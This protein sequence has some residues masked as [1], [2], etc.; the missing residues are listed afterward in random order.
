MA[1]ASPLG[2]FIERRTALVERATPG[3]A[4]AAELARLTNEAV[5]AQVSMAS[6]FIGTPFAVFALG[7]YG[8]GRLLPGSDID[9]LIVPTGSSRDV[10]PLVRCLLYP[11]WDA[12][13]TVGHQIRTPKDQLRAVREDLTVATSFLTARCVAGDGTLAK[14]VIG[15]VFARLARDRR[16]L[17]ERVTARERPGSPYQLEP[18]LKDGAGGQR[19]IDELVWRAALALGAPASTPVGLLESGLLTDPEALLLES[20]QDA[21]TGA[22]WVVH[23]T[24]ARVSNTLCAME[25]DLLLDAETTQRALELTH[26]TLI[27]VRDRAARRPPAPPD[28]MSLDEI[29]GLAQ[30]GTPGLAMLERATYAGRLEH[31]IPGLQAMMALRRPSLSHRYTVGAHSLRVLTV[32]L[33]ASATKPPAEDTLHALVIAALTHDLGKQTP[34]P[35]HAARSATLTAEVASRFGLSQDVG[36]AAEVLVREHLLL[37]EVAT[38]RDLTDEDVI[39]VSAARIGSLALV[40]PLFALTAADMRATGPDV[41]TPWRATLVA[42]LAN[43]LAD[44]LSPEIDGAGII[45]AAENTRE[46][47]RVTALS[48]GASRVVL[49][50]LEQAPLRYLAHR[51]AKE[52]LRDAL[53]VQSIAGPGAPGRFALGISPGPTEGTWV[54]DLIT[55]DRPGLFAII[56]GTL[57]LCGLDTLAAEAHAGEAGI[58]LDTFTVTSATR[59]PVGTETWSAV[60][61]VLCAALA[62]RYDIDTRLAKRRLHYPASSDTAMPVVRTLTAT[63]LTATVSIKT[64]DR[65]GLLHDLAWAC[66]SADLDIRRAVITTRGNVA[67]DVFELTDAEGAPPSR[68]TITETLIPLLE[69]AAPAH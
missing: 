66:R 44:A 26:H 7:G 36:A 54:M 29:V 24:S 61:R 69:Q 12:G 21:I 19:D 53:L 67:D 35:G 4:A 13:L 31:A 3:T 51:D 58:A 5:F 46:A 20:A 56:S 22:R 52:V 37:S 33:D 64:P 2:W 49:G 18:D 28:P 14:H 47:A 68:E 9:L 23:R 40:E 15:S 48:R 38:T 30:T 62:G 10:E 50:F 65:V 42:E 6:S 43:K 1:A 57:S 59:A 8:A 16:S 41:W 11:L 55:R 17:L 34:G 60:E 39:L 25:E 45:A 63:R 32:L 27:T